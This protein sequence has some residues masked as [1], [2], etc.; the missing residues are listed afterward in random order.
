[1]WAPPNT[2]VSGD[3]SFAT[4]QSHPLR[5]E[6]RAGVIEKIFG[7]GG[8]ADDEP[9]PLLANGGKASRAIGIFDERERGDAAFLFFQFFIGD[10]IDAPIGDRRGTDRDIDRQRRFRRRQHLGAVS[11]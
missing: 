8:K 7:L 6:F 2:P 5:F 3:T 4:I 10:R 9:R 1:M 11:T